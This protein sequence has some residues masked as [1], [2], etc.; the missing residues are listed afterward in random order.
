[1][2][3]VSSLNSSIRS[4]Q[5]PVRQDP[6]FLVCTV[7]VSLFLLTASGLSQEEESSSGPS[8]GNDGDEIVQEIQFEGLNRFDSVDLLSQ[9]Q[10]SEGK[11]FVERIL[12]NDIRRLYQ[13]GAIKRVRWNKQDVD[14]GVRINL[15][16]QENPKIQSVELVGVREF[17][18]QSLLDEMEIIGART[19]DQNKLN[20]DHK[21]IKDKYQERGYHFVEVHT[22]QLEGSSGIILRV[23]VVEGPQ[24]YIEEIQAEGVE[25]FD[26]STVIG[27]MKS[28]PGW[29]FFSSAYYR[30]ERLME[31]LDRIEKFYRERGYLDAEAR[32]KRVTFNPEKTEAFVTVEV[33]EGK[34][35]TVGEIVFEGNTYFERKKL[36]D[37]IV[38]RA[39]EPFRLDDVTLDRQSINRLYG[40]NSYIDTQVDWRYQVIEG[41]DAVRLVFQITERGETQTGK[42]EIKGNTKTMDKVVRR[43]ISLEPGEPLNL[44]KLR[45]S[46]QNL[47]STRYFQQVSVDRS[48]A[49]DPG[50]QDVTVEVKEKNTGQIR[51]GGGFSSDVGIIGIFQIRENNFDISK[52]PGSL[53]DLI[54][55]NAFSGAGQQLS[56]TARPG[57]ERSRY[58]ISFR[59]PYLFDQPLG[60]TVE[61][62]IFEQVF[63]DYDIN[64]RGASLGF[65]YR[66]EDVTISNRFEREVIE[67]TNIDSGSPI[68][69]R[70]IE[71]ENVLLSTT[72]GISIDKRNRQIT[73]SSGYQFQTS[74]KATTGDFKYWKWTTDLRTYYPL[75]SHPKTGEH[76][77][78][79][80]ARYGWMDPY[81]NGRTPTFDRF[82]A[83]GTRT[84]RGFDYRSISPRV[85]D[86]EIGGNTRWIG[87][88]E[89]TF[90]LFRSS[91]RP[92]GRRIDYLRG[93]L[94]TD[95][96]TVGF[97]NRDLDE[98]IRASY[99][100]GIRFRVPGVNQRPFALDFAFPIREVDGDE[101]RV[102]S[103]DIGTSF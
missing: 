54:K 55:G 35:Y 7:L 92:G 103:F 21:K 19:M 10:T 60:M 79:F 77:L 2:T 26:E 31:D 16:V 73:P 88:L 12:R 61:G 95:A 58:S 63:E 64:R 6:F 46:I 14:G 68:D 44:V 62:S 8:S 36:M 38:L 27:A 97:E 66:F 67:G 50:V 75:Y 81:D 52:P 20:R 5:R 74:Y 32:L 99:G 25:A 57:N 24:V 91:R 71:G 11:P 47:R 59:E 40:K 41:E 37:E 3:D 34:Q 49:E 87:N 1:M 100:F 29:F 84:I 85:G 83:G 51:F 30:K 70:D 4:L 94:F 90:P 42:I 86:V 23:E 15:I 9:M 45:E 96:G 72:P 22:K 43:N 102:F 33:D 89:Y 82:F 48:P 28:D 53:E 65:D 39:G 69:L 13:V 93:A 80:R 56:I 17:T 78:S 101:T 98:N 18:K 76:I